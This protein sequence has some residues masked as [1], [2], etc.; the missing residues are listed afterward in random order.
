MRS[1]QGKISYLM[2]GLAITTLLLCCFFQPNAQVVIGDQNKSKQKKKEKI[3]KEQKTN[4][5]S[6]TVYIV[7]NWSNT[8]RSLQPNKGFYGDSVGLRA[9]EKSLNTWSFGLGMQ[10]KI[11]KYLFWDGGIGFTRNGESYKFE[12]ADTSYT[13]TSL[14]SYIAMPIRLNVSYGS[15]FQV[16]G[17]LG[18]VPQMF[19]GFKQEVQW[20]NKD[21]SEG[22]ETIKT[23]N[24]YNPFVISAVFNAGFM[25]HFNNGWGLIVSPEARV[26]LISTY[27][28]QEGYIQKARCFGV[29][30]G[31]IKSL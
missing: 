29:S 4:D 24:G 2:K 10:N 15:K 8:F 9:N 22:S 25:Y 6:T 16:Y 17:G 12:E 11:N 28:K 1:G 3:V 19:T 23:K 26:Q 27:G 7:T 18:L 30:F 20:R 14:Y 21:A 31:L 13:Y 5:G